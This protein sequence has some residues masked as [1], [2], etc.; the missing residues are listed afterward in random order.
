MIF[1]T[2]CVS[3]TRSSLDADGVFSGAHSGITRDSIAV[4]SA[5]LSLIFSIYSEKNVA[6]LW[7]KVCGSG[8]DGSK[9]DLTIRRPFKPRKCLLIR[10]I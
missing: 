6:K 7:H 1:E 4:T 3:V 9:L 10:I 2:S 8:A 5:R